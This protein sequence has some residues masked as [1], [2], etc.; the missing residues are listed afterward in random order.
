[1]R[2]VALL[3]KITVIIFAVLVA[4][5]SLALLHC[6]A[7]GQGGFP[8]TQDNAVELFK[9]KSEKCRGVQQN[10]NSTFVK[11]LDL[12]AGFLAGRLAR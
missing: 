5:Q 11:M 4:V 1:M 10:L 9:A 6:V 3:A 12:G 2:D 8:V 7:I